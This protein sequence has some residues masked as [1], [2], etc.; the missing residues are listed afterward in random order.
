METI[1]QRLGIKDDDV[2]GFY[3]IASRH[4]A[5]LKSLIA[6][7]FCAITSI[8]GMGDEEVIKTQ[9]QVKSFAELGENTAAEL[10]E[11]LDGLHEALQLLKDRADKTEDEINK[12][13]AKILMG[14]VKMLLDAPFVMVEAVQAVLEKINSDGL[15]VVKHT[16]EWPSQQEG[17]DDAQ[18]VAK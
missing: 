15:P 8:E 10:E 16:A 12:H 11:I 4:M 13:Q 14:T 3:L 6:G 5:H 9:E 17:K 1:A 7:I 2:T 18:E